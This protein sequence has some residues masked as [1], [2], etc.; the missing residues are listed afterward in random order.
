MHAR[1][2]GIYEPI[3]L[4]AAPPGD[5]IET[6]LQHGSHA[7]HRPERERLPMSSFDQRDGRPM[8]SSPDRDVLLPHPELDSHGA[9]CDPDFDRIHGQSLRTGSWPPVMRELTTPSPRFH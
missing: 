8:N 9:E 4:A 3:Q 5:H 1:M 6:H 2:A 7:G